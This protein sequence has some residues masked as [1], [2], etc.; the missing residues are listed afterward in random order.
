MAVADSSASRTS[1]P[2]TGV[3]VVTDAVRDASTWIPRLR[4]ELSRVIVGHERLLDRLLIAL[5]ADGHVLLEGGPGTGKQLAVRTFAAALGCEFQH[6]GCTPDLERTDLVGTQGERG[7][8]FTN[9]L[10]AEDLDEAPPKIRATLVHA[11][12]DR[13]VRVESTL[14]PLPEPFFLVATCAPSLADGTCRLTTVQRDRFLLKI[15]VPAPDAAH[16]RALIDV[17]SPGLRTPEVRAVTEPAEIRRARMVLAAIYMDGS[18]KDYIVR[19]VHATRRPRLHGLPPADHLRFEASP[20]ATLGLVAAAKAR[21]FLDGR[22]YAEH[23]DVRAVAADVFRHRVETS[24]Q[25]NELEDLTSEDFIQ[26][27]LEAVPVD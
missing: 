27:I 11:G 6:L 7:P 22:G 12:K 8:L 14:L 13:E 4:Q 19:L 16:E 9:V 3:R 20:R 10:Y 17:A 5:L 23:A 21:A 1:I 18:V 15:T 24:P 25:S 26:R 2:P